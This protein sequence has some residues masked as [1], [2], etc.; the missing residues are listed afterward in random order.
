MLSVGE[1]KSVAELERQDTLSARGTRPPRS[2]RK[3]PLA[4]V[5]LMWVSVVAVIVGANL[6]GLGMAAAV[7]LGWLLL[8]FLP[9]LEDTTVARSPRLGGSR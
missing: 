2:R 8:R 1:Q 6:P 5:V 3:T 9:G 4:F 7:G